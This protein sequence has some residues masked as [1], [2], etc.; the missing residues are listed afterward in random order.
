M[1]HG[2]RASKACDHCREAKSKCVKNVTGEGCKRCEENNLA[3][4]SQTPARRRGPPKGYL[5]LVEAH[6]HELEAVMGVILS[7]P[8]PSVQEAL[9]SLSRDSFASGVINKVSLSPF[10]PTAMQKSA[11]QYLSE[12]NCPTPPPQ[13]TNA[14]QLYALRKYVST[15][16]LNMD[17]PPPLDLTAS[18][19]YQFA[20]AERPLEELPTADLESAISSLTAMSPISS[21]SG[22]LFTP[23]SGDVPFPSLDPNTKQNEALWMNWMS[24]P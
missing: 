20:D 11:E 3:C 16:G 13:P 4:T 18:T 5:H 2:R 15:T 12:P 23:R 8:D 24:S 21:S 14:W 7:I 9:E 1:A 6:M 19:L 22:S 17:S 10:G